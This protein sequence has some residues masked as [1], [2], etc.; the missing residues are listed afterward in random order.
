MANESKRKEV[1]MI[2]NNH[3]ILHLRAKLSLKG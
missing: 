1:I 3:F 2:R